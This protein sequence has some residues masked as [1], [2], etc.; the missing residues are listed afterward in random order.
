M[1]HW[2]DLKLNNKR[3]NA[4]FAPKITAMK[5]IITITPLS[6]LLLFCSCRKQVETSFYD[7][8]WV[9]K[10]LNGQTVKITTGT[11]PF[12]IFTK[13]TQKAVGKS[14]CNTFGNDFICDYKTGGSIFK[15]TSLFTTQVA[16]GDIETTFYKAINISD[17][18]KIEANQLRLS[19]LLS[20]N[21]EPLAVFEGQ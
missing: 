15:V 12:I 20:S 9:L 6:I 16:C 11:T 3:N 19:S 4:L 5:K 7:T 2:L 21:S 10:K 18:A 14:P 8:K 17:F 13:N 1:V